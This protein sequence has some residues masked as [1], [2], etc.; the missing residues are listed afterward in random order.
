MEELIRRAK[1]KGI[2]VEDL[3]ISAIARE[4]PKEGI[5]LKLMLAERFMNE[6]DEYLK[7]G[8]PV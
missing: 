8:D 5:K 7:K 2:E 3:I 1:E 6:V 4:D